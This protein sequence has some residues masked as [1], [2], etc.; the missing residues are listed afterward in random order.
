MAKYNGTYSCG[1]EG[2][3]ELYGPMKNRERK[4]EWIFSDICPAC[5]REKDAVERKAANQK[6]AV[7]SEEYGLPELN[8]SEKQVAWANTLRL[9]ILEK[10]DQKVDEI[11]NAG[12]KGIR[13]KTEDGQE[14]YATIEELLK[15]EGYLIKNKVEARF[16]IDSREDSLSKILGQGIVENRKGQ[17]VPEDI[18]QEIEEEK[19]ALTVRPLKGEQKGGIVELK[20]GSDVEARY[21]KDDE[22]R[23]I[24]KEFGYKWDGG[25]WR[26]KVTEY[27]G[28]PEERAA[29]LGNALLLSGFT[30][31][32]PD[33]AAMYKAL[34][35]E[36]E[37]ECTRWVKYNEDKGKLSI[38]WKG[39]NDTVYHAAKKIPGAR[40]ADGKIL[41]PVERYKEVEDFS[42]TL[43]FKI[44]REAQRKINQFKASESQ[45]FRADVAKAVEEI[46]DADKL[47]A[48]LEKAG[49]IE[50]LIDEIE[51]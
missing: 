29:E 39:R 40:Y 8:G 27:T 14:W 44:A 38:C 46:P 16:W 3:V 6:S 42:D 18:E 48:K 13:I 47:K 24:V 43:G 23:A 34:S 28:E 7:K 10:I 15:A 2:M 9:A 31:R 45:F 49:I 36:F 11:I 17:D 5:R 26:K 35:G 41:V 37:K 21:E 4:A 32:F 1:H 20:I 19:A 30:V 22:F 12:K 25:C 33:K 51:E 50:D